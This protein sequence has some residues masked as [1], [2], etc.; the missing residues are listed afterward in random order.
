MK[1][2]IFTLW[3]TLAM[4]FAATAQDFR[5]RVVNQLQMPIS[6]AIITIEGV[7]RAVTDIDGVVEIDFRRIRP[8]YRLAAHAIGY[9]SLTQEVGQG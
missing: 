6:Y 2:L 1:R 7:P 4:A 9:Q 8:E 3:L 5:V